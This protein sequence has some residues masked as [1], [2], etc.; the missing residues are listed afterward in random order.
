M[1]NGLPPGVRF[2]VNV[3]IIQKKNNRQKEI[4]A[5]EKEMKTFIT[6]GEVIKDIFNPLSNAQR[7]MAINL[8]AIV[9]LMI[10]KGFFTEE[11]FNDA[12]LKTADEF[13][14][15]AQQQMVEQVNRSN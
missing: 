1:S 4:E 14:K 7:H 9:S 3:P 15:V 13:Q 11:E 5:F 12:L 6:K 8:S 10:E 2:P